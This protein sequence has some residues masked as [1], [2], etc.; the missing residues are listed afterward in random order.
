MSAHGT[1]KPA[2]ASVLPDG[3]VHI[4]WRE[5]QRRVAIGQSVVLYDLT[6]TYVL[7]GGLNTT[8]VT[9]ASAAVTLG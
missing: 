3:R 2:T 5:P 4:A 6:D 1:P 7:G 8:A 9:L